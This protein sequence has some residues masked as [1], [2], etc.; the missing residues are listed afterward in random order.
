MTSNS[1]SAVSRDCP[2]CGGFLYEDGD[3]AGRF[4]SCVNCGELIPLDHYDPSGR[5]SEGKHGVRGGKRT[6]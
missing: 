5:L 4:L 3:L 1:T 2:R 6:R